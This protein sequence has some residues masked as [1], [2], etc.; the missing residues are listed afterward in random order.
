MFC[1]RRAVGTVTMLFDSFSVNPIGQLQRHWNKFWRKSIRCSYWRDQANGKRSIP[2]T[3]EPLGPY[4]EIRILN[5]SLSLVV[6]LI[7]SDAFRWP[8]TR[9]SS[10][11][12]SP[13]AQSLRTSHPTLRGV[14]H[15][16]IAV[17]DREHAQSWWHLDTI[18][19]AMYALVGSNQFGSISDDWSMMFN[20]LVD[21]SVNGSSEFCWPRTKSRLKW[22]L[23]LWTASLLV[24]SLSV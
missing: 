1:H 11:K 6:F 4:W 8:S 23:L 20:S 13:I 16:W 17:Q 7:F 22:V 24:T 10:Y 2:L 19:N 12:F 14:H 18:S 3:H 15:G 5:S 9:F 21:I